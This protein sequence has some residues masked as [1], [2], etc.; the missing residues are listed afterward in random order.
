[1][2]FD[3]YIIK[4]KKNVLEELLSKYFQKDLND[5][6]YEA[7]EELEKKST[8]KLFTSRVNILRNIEEKLPYAN[9]TYVYLT[10]ENYELMLSHCGER[11][12]YLKQYAEDDFSS[13]ELGFRECERLFYWLRGLNP[14]WNE[15]VIIYEHD[16]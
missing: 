16:C 14:N 8:S 2:G 11:L 6:P 12:S 5:L 13:K 10:K 3:M 9:D 1:M 7:F 15:D 4:A